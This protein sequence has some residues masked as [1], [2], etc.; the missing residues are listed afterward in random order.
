MLCNNIFIKSG[1]KIILCF[2]VVTVMAAGTLYATP[3][4][5]KVVARKKIGVEK[6]VKKS[7]S[8]KIS[9]VDNKYVSIVVNRNNETKTEDEMGFWIDGEV[10][11][12]FR[13][14]LSEMKRGDRIQIEYDEVFQD[15]EEVKA[16]GA[17]ERKTKI[18]KLRAKNIKF[19][20]PAKS[21]LS[22]DK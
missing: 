20:A 1:L 3:K 22:S 12:N 21:S 18:D 15:Y 2:L 14:K 4:A 5:D 7:I 13:K 16:N 19:L 11:A 8:G 17:V 9:Y 10:Q 6:P